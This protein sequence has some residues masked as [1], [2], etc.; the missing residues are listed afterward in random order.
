MTLTDFQSSTGGHPAAKADDWWSMAAPTNVGIL[1]GSIWPIKSLAR[2]PATIEITT[3]FAGS[4][5]RPT[6]TAL[7]PV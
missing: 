4:P 7:V 5:K 6:C 2:R 1:D 3:E